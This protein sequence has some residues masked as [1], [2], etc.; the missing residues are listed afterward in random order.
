VPIDAH[1][2]K[3]L[4][5]GM[6]TEVLITHAND[7]SLD[8]A[9][10]VRNYTVIQLLF[11]L[12]PNSGE[13]LSVPESSSGRIRNHWI[14]SECIYAGLSEGMEPMKRGYTYNVMQPI[15]K[16]TIPQAPVVT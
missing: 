13:F 4:Y 16:R 7:P 3:I 9:F 10:Q 5:N 15:R 6:N 11:E 14:Q 2:Q 12:V 1:G 8:G